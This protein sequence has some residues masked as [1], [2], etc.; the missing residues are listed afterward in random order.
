MGNSNETDDEFAIRV[1]DGDGSVFGDIYQKYGIAIERCI[2]KRFPKLAADAEDIV[3][4]A[5]RRLIRSHALY[6]GNRSIRA[7]IYSIAFNVA[8]EMVSG[9][10]KWQKS[11]NQEK[12][13]P[14][15]VLDAIIPKHD[16]NM[17]HEVD[18]KSPLCK[19]VQASLA[20]L[21]PI[22]RDVLETYAFA[23]GYP[24]KP[25]ELGKELGEKHCNGVPMPAGT[26]RQHK[27]RAKAKLE[28]EMRKRGFDLQQVGAGR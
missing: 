13:L 21:T 16:G 1:L 24:V 17:N 7:Y 15:P 3:A 19:A 23:D 2:E 25:T 18:E 6:D 5:F 22:Q 20:A 26:I 10:L 11:R 12:P 14:T 27:A 9:H 4:E 8:R 28:A